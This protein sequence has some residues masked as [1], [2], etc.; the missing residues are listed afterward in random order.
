M[1]L[2]DLDPERS[3]RSNS[4][5]EWWDRLTADSPLWS[6]EGSLAREHFPI[7]DPQ[8]ARH[9]SRTEA[10]SSASSGLT[11]GEDTGD[12]ATSAA[13][14]AAAA[15]AAAAGGGAHGSS[16]HGSS[17]DSAGG[18]DAGS[19]GGAG[20]GS[21]RGAG[22]RDAATGA[23][24]GRSSWVLV[25]SLRESA[26]ALALAAL[27]GDG[28][29]CVAEAEDLLFARDR[30]TCALADRVGRVHRAG[31]AKQHGHASTRS[32]LR[33]AA[34]MS[35]AGAGRLLTL[36]VE[37]ARL[38]RVREKFAAG[39]LSAGVV[40]AIC[41]AT[42][43][44]SDEHAGLA[45][46][47]LLELA[48]K[49]GPAEVAKAGRYL[50]AVLDPDGEDRDERADY[51]R[52]FLRVR[53][54]AGGGLEGEF[55]LPREAAARLRALLDAY[56]KPRA[57]GDDRPLRVR[58]ADAFIALMEQ[59][60]VAELLVLVNAESLPTDP[61]PDQ[62]D[63]PEDP[64]PDH[65]ETTEATQDAQ[66]AEDTKGGEN[67]K[68]T[69]G[70]EDTEDGQAVD[71]AEDGWGSENAKDTPGTE[72]AEGGRDSENA[73]NAENAENGEGTEGAQQGGEGAGDGQDAQ[74]AAEGAASAE[75]GWD[76]EDTGL[77]GDTGSV[78]GP[79]PVEGGDVD[80]A[81]PGD[82]DRRNLGDA[83]PGDVGD[84]GMTGA[85][86]PAQGEGPHRPDDP[87]TADAEAAAGPA[88]DADAD[89][90]AA[91]DAAAGSTDLDLAS[92]EGDDTAPPKAADRDHAAA[93]AET[94]PEPAPAWPAYGGSAPA[95]AAP[96]HAAPPHAA[97]PSAAPPRAAQWPDPPPE[98]AAAHHAHAGHRP[99][100]DCRHA[101]GTPENQSDMRCEQRRHE[102]DRR[103]EP[104]FDEPGSDE[105]GRDQQD[106]ADG[107]RACGCGG[108][109][110]CS[111]TSGTTGTA[112]GAV[113]EAPPGEPEP[114]AAGTPLG[115]A[116][117][118]Q[119]GTPSGT[120]SRTLPGAAPGEPGPGALLGTAPG[121]LLATG[122][123]LPLASVH[124]LA[125]TSS[126]V[127]MVTDAEGQVLDMG[128]KV[129]LATPAQ[130][131]AVYARYATCWI[132]GC[133]LPATMCQIDHADN[134]STGGLT[135]LKLLGPA[136][137]FHNR[138]RYQHPD[139]Y[140]RH[141]TGTDRWAFTYQPTRI[142][143]LRE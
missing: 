79:C 15:A 74:D 127:R 5:G 71:Y 27:P 82:D 53:P 58:Q 109:V 63:H 26:Q 122:Q 92:T 118:R 134:W 100:G 36:A 6:S 99:A 14:A 64:A 76:G 80:D 40:E 72:D 55:Y 22:A 9:A 132:D 121:L 114:G 28:D 37:L 116:P 130:R 3:R 75:D 20:A 105:Q 4:S 1:D 125:R 33:T 136:C 24:G 2:F 12:D 143:R 35:V 21:A 13:S 19:T 85:A 67:A 117:G 88:S 54:T 120:A 94:D 47:I 48:G 81:I 86:A 62:P 113:P 108:E 126:L 17:A 78:D 137:Q 104:G 139:R 133:P 50:R 115:A 45:E 112:P 119:A 41:T 16:A 68:D 60:I 7:A 10:D 96:P 59:K 49:A 95:H 111:C 56:A 61:E 65:P 128:R 73:E 131:R 18:A 110:R 106:A 57:E 97:P 25:G 69:Q 102:P 46:P 142:N 103:C 140:T 51:G 31:Q 34:G 84:V 107:Q 30:I 129:R 83:D 32:W 11:G 89:A 101:L 87:G 66:S 124:R 39:V 43:R 91:A 70:T 77:S 135:D 52:R 123:M 93:Q 29:I 8:P 42:A 141:K 138:D 98:D 38:P 44:L 23:A 90:G